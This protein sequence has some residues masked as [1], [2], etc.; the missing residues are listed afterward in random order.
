MTVPK[1]K[2]E[3][4][5]QTGNFLKYVYKNAAQDISC[6]T[7]ETYI[8][9]LKKFKPVRRNKRQQAAPYVVKDCPEVKKPKKLVISPDN[10]NM[11]LTKSKSNSGQ[12]TSLP[13]LEQCFDEDSNSTAKMSILSVTTTP[14][15][16]FNPLNILKNV[17]KHTRDLTEI[18]NKPDVTY[19]LHN[20]DTNETCPSGTRPMH[21]IQ[22]VP[23][24]QRRIGL[25]QQA[26]NDWKY[27]L[28]LDEDGHL[29]IH[30]AVLTNDIDL[31]KRQ[32]ITL[33]SRGSSVDIPADGM[34]PLKMSLFQE[35]VEI[36]NMLLQFGA[37]PLE[38]DD[39][40]RTSF[41]IAA[42][43]ATD[44]LP[45]LVNYC[46]QNARKILQENEELWRPNYENKTDDE[47]SSILLTYINKLYDCQ[48]YTPLML[49]SKLGKYNNVMALAENSRS[50]VN[51][52]MPNSGNTALFLAVGA[53]CM[54]AAE[55]GDRTKI[56]DH[57]R[58]TVE[59][60]LDHGAE[61][62]VQNFGGC[63]A[64]DLLAEFNIGEL[65]ML[66]ANKI[67]TTRFPDSKLP[68]GLK[69][70]EFMLI[71][72]SKGHVNI[73]ELER[74]PLKKSII[75]ENVITYKAKNSTSNLGLKKDGIKVENFKLDKPLLIQ[76]KQSSNKRKLEIVLD[77]NKIKKLDEKD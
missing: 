69:G 33:K 39:D 64:N 28:T 71:K 22:H 5:T 76:S 41:H 40:D 23:P 13:V 67:A 21:N 26:I 45:V 36:T 65:S 10:F 9:E 72:D 1:K 15:L 70:S 7:N 44:H 42:E 63:S 50:A 3:E 62:N 54:D 16:L 53:A 19:T 8:R 35:N 20:L 31:L 56:V 74:K 29:P 38:V 32:C 49:A 30:V 14:D 47:L 4:G 17:D 52:R 73:E 25:L 48:G 2:H 75:V 27:S 43:L 6:Q 57:F 68:K 24:G 61:P 46:C 55:R 51:S 12:S 59:I 60:L 18:T 77:V 58:K 11:I 66:I 34:T 37:D